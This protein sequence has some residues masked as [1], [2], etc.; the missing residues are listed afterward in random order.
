MKREISGTD[1]DCNLRRCDDCELC[2]AQGT[3]GEQIQAIEALIN[4]TKQD[5]PTQMS[6]TYDLV[7]RQYL[8]AEYDRQHKGPPGGAR[9]IIEE[10]P[11]V[12]AEAMQKLRHLR[13]D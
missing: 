10:A 3:C 8:L 12:M 4:A 11:A 6:G 1:I 9:K 5:F 2:Y 13:R 7:S